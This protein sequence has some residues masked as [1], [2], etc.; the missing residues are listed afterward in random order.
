MLIVFVKMTGIDVA[1][2]LAW[3]TVAGD[4]PIRGVTA[5]QGA[6]LP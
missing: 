6:C 3:T 1:K 2:A 5:E 4:G